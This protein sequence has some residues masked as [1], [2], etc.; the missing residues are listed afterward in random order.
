MIL[1]INGVMEDIPAHIDDPYGNKWYLS[2]WHDTP[3][4]KWVI[5]YVNDTESAFI[6]KVEDAD[7]T[8][9]FWKM[10]KNLEMPWENYGMSS[11]V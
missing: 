8:K 10:H 1:E 5:K 4:K 11:T 2:V 6:I 3:R 7:I 9:A